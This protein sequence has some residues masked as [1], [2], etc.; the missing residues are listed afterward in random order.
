MVRAPTFHQ[1][2]FRLERFATVAIK[3]G[4]LLFEDVAGVI[5]SLNELAAA[6]MM[7]RLAGLDK[8]GI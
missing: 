3:T 2:F 7:A 4:I 6:D 5:N 1:L 8:V